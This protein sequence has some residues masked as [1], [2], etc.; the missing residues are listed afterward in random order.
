M[1]VSNDGKIHQAHRHGLTTIVRRLPEAVQMY[2]VCEVNRFHELQTAIKTHSNIL[3]LS[4]AGEDSVILTG[5]AR[6][7]RAMSCGPLR[8][9]LPVG[10]FTRRGMI[11]PPVWVWAPPL[12]LR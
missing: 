5:A 7:Q 12:R 3:H 6:L 11:L 10:L 9:C 4:V 2:A 1:E 8:A